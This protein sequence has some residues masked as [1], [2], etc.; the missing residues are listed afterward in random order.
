MPPWPFFQGLKVWFCSAEEQPFCRTIW[1]EEWSMNERQKQSCLCLSW[2]CINHWL[3][4]DIG[5]I[6]PPEFI[7]PKKPRLYATLFTCLEEWILEVRGECFVARRT[8]LSQVFWASLS[9]KVNILL[10]IAQTQLSFP[11][12]FEL[13]HW[14]DPGQDL[15]RAEEQ[16]IW[17]RVR[18]AS[19]S[20]LGGM[21]MSS[22]SSAC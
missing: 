19:L 1:Y 8:S 3:P 15:V 16:A 21:E 5:E 17:A 11:S 10:H 22:S 4:V 7:P 13:F 14:F 9:Y 20:Q 6:N 18:A 12:Q 2:I